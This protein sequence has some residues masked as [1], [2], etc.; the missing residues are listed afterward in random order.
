MLI[1]PKDI[2]LPL[3]DSTLIHADAAVKFSLDSSEVPH[4]NAA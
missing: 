1:G 2:D 4:L 3:F